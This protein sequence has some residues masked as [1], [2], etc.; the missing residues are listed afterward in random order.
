MG[1][2]KYEYQWPAGGGYELSRPAINDGYFAEL[3]LEYEYAGLAPQC[4]I[5]LFARY[6]ALQALSQ[7]PIEISTYGYQ[8]LSNKI[9]YRRHTWTLGGSITASFSSPDLPTVFGL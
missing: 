2:L 7:D 4:E 6:T 8:G 3:S 5:A 9:E 1:H